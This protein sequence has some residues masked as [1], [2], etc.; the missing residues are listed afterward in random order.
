M[1][2]QS[3]YNISEFRLEGAEFSAR[4]AFN[5][6]HE[7]FSGHFPGQPVVPGVCLIHIIKEIANMILA[8]ELQMTNAG[9]VK[10][11]HMIDPNENPEVSIRGSFKIEEEVQVVINANI[12]GN[13]LVFCKFK[14]RFNNETVKQ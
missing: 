1:S 4:I 8:R 6:A 14:G 13:D 2:L 3:L 5:P 7:I 11:L 10:F 12:S 9:N